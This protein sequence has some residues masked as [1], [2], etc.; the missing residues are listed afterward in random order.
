M[1]FTQANSTTGLKK[2]REHDT[3]LSRSPTAER[4]NLIQFQNIVAAKRIFFL[5]EKR[6][7]RELHCRLFWHCF[8]KP[9]F[10][11]FLL[12]V[13]LSTFYH[14]LNNNFFYRSK[15]SVLFNWSRK[16]L[17]KTRFFWKFAHKCINDSL[18][19]WNA[20]YLRI[21]HYFLNCDIRCSSNFP[22][23]VSYSWLKW[24]FISQSLYSNKNY[25]RR[26]TN[27]S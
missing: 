15:E 2:E 17:H 3:V 10:V 4:Q 20:W 9:A 23:E 22:N 25:L 24:I 5:I 18:V 14:T 13:G 11:V 7:S 8:R 6:I 27:W 1:F 21:I 12:K 26:D 19:L 16:L